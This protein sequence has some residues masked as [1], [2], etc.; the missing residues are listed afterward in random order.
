MKRTQKLSWL[1]AILLL[2]GSSTR[3]F[4]QTLK[5]FFGSSEAATVYLGIDFTK[6]K[7]INSPTANP[8]DI[9]NRIYRSINDVVVNEPKKFD[10]MGAFHKTSVSTDLSA[11]HARNEKINAEE[12][13]SSKSDDFN[14]LKEGDITTVVKALNISSKKGV[15]ILFVFEA[16]KSIE[17]SDDY[18]SVWTV[19]VDLQTKKVLLT[20]RFEVKAKGLGFRNTWA[21]AIKSTL[22]EIEKRKYEAW[23]DK[24]GS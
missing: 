18:A 22:D 8:M 6:A 4:G 3:S 5:D 12:I 19:L 11:V 1:F 21:S 16:M 7:L 2:L 14:R 9:K 23:K 13:V 20:E 15:G 24:Y 17:K 10:F